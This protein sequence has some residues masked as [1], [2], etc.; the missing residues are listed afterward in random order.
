MLDWENEHY[1]AYLRARHVLDNGMAF[2]S[3]HEFKVLVFLLARSLGEGQENVTVSV[4]KMV[5]GDGEKHLGTGLSRASVIRTLSAL[6]SQ[7]LIQRT[8][9]R[10]RAATTYVVNI[11][12]LEDY[13]A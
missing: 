9:S 8:P 3:G 7:G 5:T 4:V 13:T 10:A 6:E 11:R 2:F 1:D 12:A